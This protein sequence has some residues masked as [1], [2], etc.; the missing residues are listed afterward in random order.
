MCIYVCICTERERGLECKLASR[1]ARTMVTVVFALFVI[2]FFLGKKS[3][4]KRE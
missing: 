2:M 3:F 4:I 1:I